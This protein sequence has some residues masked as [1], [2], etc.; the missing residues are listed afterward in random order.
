MH[1]SEFIQRMESRGLVCDGA[2]GTQLMARGLKPGECGERWCLERP[3]DIAAVHR[4]YR[5][6]GCDMVTTC[7]FGA[8][9]T[10]L[11][12]HG[13]SDQIGPINAAG[14]HAARRG[15]G[16]DA[17]V[18]GD[19]GPF[20]DFLEPVGTVTESELNAIFGEQMTA[21]RDAGAD[22][23]IIET[24]GD[25]AEIA[26]AVRTARRLADWP[27]LATFAFE[28]IADG[29]FRTMMGTTVAAAMD[30]VREAG[31]TVIGANCGTNLSL[32]DYRV[33]A[34]E[35]VTAARGCPVILQPNAGSPGP[36]AV[37]S[38]PEQ[39]QEFTHA[40]LNAGV[41]VIGGCC[42]TSPAHLA[43]MAKVNG[44]RR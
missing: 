33:L 2:M 34:Q 35:L 4:A 9:R 6:A 41:R 39:F 36:G 18:L 3:D 19:V 43:V 10:M 8:T 22:G 26:V 11:E 7:T 13:L 37:S 16:Q 5:D 20:G 14:V 38:T 27:V 30:A 44:L 1:A 29:S 23:V 17:I 12:R 32:A 40:L 28:R 15:A 42:G 31:A 25:P 24:M 21:L